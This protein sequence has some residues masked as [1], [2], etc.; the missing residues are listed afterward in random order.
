M[1]LTP[2]CRSSGAFSPAALLLFN[3]EGEQEL[4]QRFSDQESGSSL[5][6]VKGWRPE[7]DSALAMSARSETARRS[8]RAVSWDGRTPARMSPLLVNAF[9]RFRAVRPNTIC[10]CSSP[11][12]ARL[13]LGA[14]RRRKCGRPGPCFGRPE[15]GIDPNGVALAQPSRNESFSRVM[16]EAWMEGKPVA[17]HS[18]CLATAVAVERSGGGWAAA[19]EEEWA[20][21]L[22]FG[23]DRAL[24]QPSLSAVGTSGRRY[25]E[26]RRRM[27]RGDGSDEYVFGRP[28]T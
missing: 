26:M 6:S 1:R 16:M 5:S 11:A 2:T 20:G 9:L 28:A 10:A 27:G 13:D 23:F 7:P 19:S 15:D 21:P 8:L 18:D 25:A 14:A 3:S 17:V 22:R 4:A 24:D 12:M